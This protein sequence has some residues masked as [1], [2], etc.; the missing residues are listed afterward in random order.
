MQ[1]VKKTGEI[2]S[3]A[4]RIAISF[5]M[6]FYFTTKVLLKFYKALYLYHIKLHESLI[7]NCLTGMYSLCALR[8]ICISFPP[9]TLSKHLDLGI[10]FKQC[11]FD[12]PLRGTHPVA[13][14]RRIYLAIVILQ[15]FIV[16]GRD[17]LGQHRVSADLLL[18]YL[19][20]EENNR[21]RRTV[22]RTIAGI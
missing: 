9:T 3:A 4:D 17:L 7:V 6:I 16:V 11:L 20:A 15:F 10:V 12:I 19:S 1:E 8:E 2:S 13:H 14:D 21:L 5:F 22:I 18:M